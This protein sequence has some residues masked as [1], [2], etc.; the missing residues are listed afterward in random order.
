MATH[1]PILEEMTTP[2]PTYPWGDGHLPTYVE[3]GVCLD[4]FRFIF[5]FIYLHI[6]LLTYQ[7][8][9]GHAP[10]YLGG[11]GHPPSI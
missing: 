1:L 6:Y 3:G 9:D 8:G 10:N 7:K 2:L 5:V 11:D 4:T